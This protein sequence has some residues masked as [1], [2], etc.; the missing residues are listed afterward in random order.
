M[1]E[2]EYVGLIC[3]IRNGFA[4]VEKKCAWWNV[5]CCAV[6]S[7]AKVVEDSAAV[8]EDEHNRLERQAIWG[9]EGG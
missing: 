7:L 2:S 3:P 8:A 1:S 9:S 4:C 6:L 5:K